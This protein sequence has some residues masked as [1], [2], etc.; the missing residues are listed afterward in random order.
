MANFE[1][2]N[3]AIVIKR[4][5]KNGVISSE[6]YND[7]QQQ[8]QHDLALLFQMAN[9]S[10]LPIFDGLGA[11]GTYSDLDPV[12]YGLDGTQMLIDKDWTDTSN[13]YYWNSSIV[14]PTTIYEGFNQVIADLDSAFSQINEVKARLGTDRVDGVG[15][16]AT[17][18]ELESKVNN[19]TSLSFQLQNTT[20]AATTLS[21]VEAAIENQVINPDFHI[22]DSDVELGAA[23]NPSKISGV[24]FW[25][26][27]YNFAAD[28]PASNPY[29]IEKTVKRITQWVT[30]ITG[31]AFTAWSSGNV[32]GPTLRDHISSTGTGTVSSGNP[33]GLDV[34]DLSDNSNIL[35]AAEAERILA[36][37]EFNI[38]GSAGIIEKT[39][40]FAPINSD[41]IKVGVT[42]ID[43]TYTSIESSSSVSIEA[44]S[45]R[46]D[47]VPDFTVGTVTKSFPVVGGFDNYA[48]TTTITAP[49]APWNWSDY[50]TFQLLNVSGLV[51]N[52]KVTIWGR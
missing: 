30:D 49:S 2:L 29:T 44:S 17:L 43:L 47:A 14:R 22:I 37:L 24:V 31:D 3:P 51:Y 11:P 36:T 27:T 23:I 25:P 5:P 42:K 39:D 26:G 48:S 6:D 46:A 45:N 18:T 1:R 40:S 34:S 41:A 15:T 16:G 38:S 7:F 35:A 12:K 21:G 20:N 13:P 9:A 4:A 32:G 50:T 19:L 8:V 28:D 52:C 33:H 10:V